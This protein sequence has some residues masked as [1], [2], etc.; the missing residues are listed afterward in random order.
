MRTEASCENAELSRSGLEH[1]YREL[2]QARA[3]VSLVVDLIWSHRTRRLDLLQLNIIL[4]SV[5]IHKRK[6][7]K[8]SHKDER[9]QKDDRVQ[10]NQET[11]ASRAAFPERFTV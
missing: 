1:F 3:S 9:T 7:E 8:Q 11:I 4:V 6:A 10:C 2:L 5:S